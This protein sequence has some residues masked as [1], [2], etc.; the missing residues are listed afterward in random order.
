MPWVSV[1]LYSD[2]CF[3]SA[4]QY[5]LHYGHHVH[6]AFGV[7]SCPLALATPDPINSIAFSFPNYNHVPTVRSD[8]QQRAI[9]GHFEDLGLPLL[10]YFLT[11]LVKSVS[12]GPSQNRLECLE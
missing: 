9:T 5:G 2:G 1:S 3:D 8:L 10:V 12:S 4:A 7:G 6:V 11:V